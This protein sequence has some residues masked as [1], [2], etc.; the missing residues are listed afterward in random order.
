LGA[1]TLA[2]MP[3]LVPPL[4]LFAVCVVVVGFL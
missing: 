3:S 4:L 2:L 1:F